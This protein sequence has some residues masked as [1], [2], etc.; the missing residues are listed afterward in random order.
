MLKAEIWSLLGEE[1]TRRAIDGVVDE[2]GRLL[3]SAGFPARGPR[4]PFSMHHGFYRSRLRKAGR[5]RTHAEVAE[6]LACWAA[7]RPDPVDYARQAV[8]GAVKA[9][10]SASPELA[11]S[12]PP[13]V[14]A[15]MDAVGGG[16]E[17]RR[18]GASPVQA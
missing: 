7:Q 6:L 18:F 5:K 16:Y 2:C 15:A 10:L 1:E 17:F 8:C 9:M 3:R 12:I 11:G 13:S 4:F 14:R